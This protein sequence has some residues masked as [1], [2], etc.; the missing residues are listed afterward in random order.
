M[1][2]VWLVSGRTAG[3]AWALPE[4]ARERAWAHSDGVGKEWT[5]RTERRPCPNAGGSMR[6]HRMLLE[7]GLGLGTP[8]VRFAYHASFHAHNRA[9]RG[10]FRGV[11]RPNWPDNN[12]YPESL[13]RPRI[14]RNPRGGAAGLGGGPGGSGSGSRVPPGPQDPIPAPGVFLM[15]LLRRPDEDI[16][17]FFIL[18]RFGSGRGGRFGSG[19]APYGSGHSEKIARSRPVGRPRRA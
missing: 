19:C 9:D 5:P 15:G 10:R 17:I 18:A 11:A 16:V 3:A 2:A 12:N 1:A 7:T 4:P 6:G 14:G 13:S 8:S